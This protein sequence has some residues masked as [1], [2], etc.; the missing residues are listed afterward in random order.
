MKTTEN[1]SL[2]GYAFIIETDAYDE[3]EVYLNDIKKRFSSDDSAEEIVADI[4]ERIAELLHERCISGMVVDLSMIREIERRIGDPKEMA[5]EETDFESAGEKSPEQT[6][7][8]EKK[9]WKGRRMFR[10]MDERVI[11]GVCSGFGTYFGIDKVIFRIIFLVLF[12]IGFAGWDDGPFIM[13][14]VFAYLCLWIAMPAARTAEQKRAMK[15]RPLNLDSYRDKDFNFGKEVREVAESPAGQTAKR[16]GGVFLGIFLI[17]IGLGGLLGSIFIPS[18][19]AIIG[20]AAS[21]H[22]LD[23]GPFDQT[24]QLGV[25]LVTDPTF[26]GL[27]LVM[28]GL[29][30]IWFLYNGVMLLFDLKSPSWHPGLVIF[31]SWIVSIFIL[32]AWVVKTVAAALS[33]IV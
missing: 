32:S 26:W 11:G 22:I 5:Q 29:L 1:I 23:F 18:L 21:V 6:P 27:I 24:E 9:S 3:L 33:L 17:F 4:E 13:L 19:P 14:S 28:I 16:A 10:N 12:F 31:L 20:N 25:D 7:K 8:P 30:C 2:A 15:G